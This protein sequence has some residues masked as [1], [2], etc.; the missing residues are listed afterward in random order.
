MSDLKIESITACIVCATSVA[1]KRF[2]TEVD[3]DLYQWWCF[4]VDGRRRREKADSTKCALTFL[5][6]RESFGFN[7]FY[8]IYQF[9]HMNRV[10]ERERVGSGW[11]GT[12]TNSLSGYFHIDELLKAFFTYSS[13]SFAFSFVFFR[14]VPVFLLGFVCYFAKLNGT[15]RC[16]S[17]E[18]SDFL[19]SNTVQT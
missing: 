6:K 12:V 16:V 5:E 19:L 3:T 11:E 8:S 13:S 17:N 1:L 7:F 4:D 2:T 18:G 15:D 14:F 9:I 10:R